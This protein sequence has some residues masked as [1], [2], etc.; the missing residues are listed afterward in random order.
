MNTQRD[1]AALVGRVLLALAFIISG[2][3]KVTDFVGTTSLIASQGLPLPPLLTAVSIAIEL[4]GGLAIA[5]G[6]KTRWAALALAVFLIVITPVFHAFWAAPPEQVMMQN[7]NFM[8]NVSI[9]GG[10]LL[11]FAFGPGRF[12][13]DRA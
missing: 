3:G 2:F 6:W 8:K 12:S 10:A 13:I 7:I 9:L 11:L 5:A 4:G 1:W